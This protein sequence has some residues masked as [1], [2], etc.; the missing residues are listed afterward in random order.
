MRHL[1]YFDTR[2][3]GGEVKRVRIAKQLAPVT[4]ITKTK[5]RELARPI[6]AD[7]KTIQNTLLRLRIALQ[8]LLSDLFTAH[9]AAEA[10][11]PRKRVMG[12]SGRIT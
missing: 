10:A 6:L 4:G 8:T 2:V 12:S 11:I 3:I 5:A 7:D 1:R 9:G